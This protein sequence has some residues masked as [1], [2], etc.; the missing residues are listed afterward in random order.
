MQKR[1]A[2]VAKVALLPLSFCSGALSGQVSPLPSPS[3]IM[4][5]EYTINPG[6]ELQIYVW[7]EERLQ[8]NVKVLP[9]GTIAFPL[10]GQFTVMGSRLS[11]LETMISE[12]L[13]NE[14]RDQ[15]PRVTVSVVQPTG[16]Q[17]TV[18]GKV[19]SP[20]VFTP[21]RTV[22]VIEALA[23]AGGPA[24]LAN[25]RKITVMRRAGGGIQTY[26]FNMRKVLKGHSK[27]VNLKDL[28]ALETGDV[29]LVP[30]K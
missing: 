17:F 4:S 10:I 7:G 27:E 29:I 1:Y 30:G 6:D 12:R 11:D 18:L 20:G 21:G 22:N 16:L 24:P 2:A 25:L 23:L 28:Q 19:N 9:D 14:Y 3:S 8:R 26:H 13:R 5:A 15:V